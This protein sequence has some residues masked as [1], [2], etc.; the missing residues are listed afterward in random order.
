[1]LPSVNK[2]LESIK[3]SQRLTFIVPVVLL[4]GVMDSAW[5][6]YQG[7]VYR[8][9]DTA[10]GWFVGLIG[11]IIFVLVR[12]RWGAGRTGRDAGQVAHRP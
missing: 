6:Y 5:S 11:M 9:R 10:E 7:G 4:A 1:M 3:P 2:I 12:R 8:M